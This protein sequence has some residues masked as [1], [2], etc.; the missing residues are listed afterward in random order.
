MWFGEQILFIPSPPSLAR[1]NFVKIFETAFVII[2]Q[3]WF[4]INMQTMYFVEIELTNIFIKELQN[5]LI[6]LII[7]WHK[8]SVGYTKNCF[9]CLVTSKARLWWLGEYTAT[10]LSGKEIVG[11]AP[12]TNYDD[13]E[14]KLLQVDFDIFIIVIFVDKWNW[15]RELTPSL[16]EN[17]FS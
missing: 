2:Y 12:F 7:L 16:Y 6:C 14:S 15:K 9:Y 3:G 11:I 4:S 1:R 13:F 5:E 8:Y 17:A 10:R